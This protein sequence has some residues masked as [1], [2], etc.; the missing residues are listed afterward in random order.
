MRFKQK[1]ASS[2]FYLLMVRLLSEDMLKSL[3]KQQVLALTISIYDRKTGKRTHWH[4]ITCKQEYSKRRIPLSTYH[5]ENVMKTLKKTWICVLDW[6]RCITI[7]LTLMVYWLTI[8]SICGNS[9]NAPTCVVC[10]TITFA[11]G[12]TL[13]TRPKVV[14]LTAALEVSAFSAANFKK[15]ATF[16]LIKKVRRWR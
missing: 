3:W 12:G 14:I 1:A 13:V 16:I 10:I 4:W 9:F 7:V 5:M 11:M 6:D 15:N 8:L 2:Q